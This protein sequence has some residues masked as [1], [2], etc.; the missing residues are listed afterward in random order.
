MCVCVCVPIFIIK[1]A[2]QIKF[3]PFRSTT[4]RFSQNR[5][6]ITSQKKIQNCSPWSTRVSK[7]Q[8]RTSRIATTVKTRIR[9]K[10]MTERSRGERNVCHF[11]QASTLIVER[12][13]ISPAVLRPHDPEDCSER[14]D[15]ARR[16]VVCLPA[17][18]PDCL[19]SHSWMHFHV[20]TGS[21]RRGV[22]AYSYVL[23]RSKDAYPSSFPGCPSLSCLFL[24]SLTV[25]LIPPNLFFNL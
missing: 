12:Q 10:E 5:I 25:F 22:R 23:V 24:C 17:C 4:L 19:P 1:C 14:G 2:A 6:E 3:Q 18:L 20:I 8:M 16:A 9:R 15:T 21:P 7:M 13:T 11:S